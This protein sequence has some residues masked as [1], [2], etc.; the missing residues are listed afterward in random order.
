MTKESYVNRKKELHEEI[1]AI[2]KALANLRKEYIEKCAPCNIGDNV[3]LVTD[4]DRK[5]TGEVKSVAIYLDDI[6]VDA[7]KPPE[8]TNVYLSKPHKSITVNELEGKI[9]SF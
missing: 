9:S 3:T 4:G 5:I 1:N 7:I 2:N 6:F 8:G